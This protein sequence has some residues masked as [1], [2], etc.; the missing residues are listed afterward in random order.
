MNKIKKIRLLD[1]N[2]YIIRKPVFSFNTLFDE[3]GKTKDLKELIVFFLNNDTFKSSIYWSSPELYD[4]MIKYCCN[5][6]KDIKILKLENTLK[7][8]IIRSTTRSVPY[9]IFAGVSLSNITDF[10]LSTKTNLNNQYAYCQIDRFLYSNIITKIEEDKIIRKNIKYQI[11]STI[12][13]LYSKY[14]YIGLSEGEYHLNTVN[15]TDIIDLIYSELS[16]KSYTISEIIKLLPKEYTY[17]ERKKFTEELIDIQFLKSEISETFYQ[18]EE[19][20]IIENFLRKL[21][22]SEELKFFLNLIVSIKSLIE[23]INNSTINFIPFD[24][25]N[26]IKSQLKNIGINTETLL[27]VDLKISDLHRNEHINLRL[28]KNITKAINHLNHLNN[29]NS[30]SELFSDFKKKFSEVYEL[31][32][33]PLMEVLDMEVGI[34]FPIEGTMGNHYN[35]S[36]IDKIV[37][38]NIVKKNNLNWAPEWLITLI[39]KQPNSTNIDLSFLSIPIPIDYEIKQLPSTFYILGSV[40]GDNSFFIQ[41]IGGTSGKPLFGRFTYLDDEIQNLYNDISN[42]EKESDPDVI[43][44]DIIFIEHGK[45]GNVTRPFNTSE[46][47]INIAGESISENIK[48]SLND[49]FVSIVNDEVILRS[50]SLNKRII[51]RL[52]NAH[53]FYQSN[54]AVYKFLA[55]IENQ[56][57][58]QIDLNLNY[59]KS[60]KKYIPRIS[61][62][63]IILK[64]ATWIIY[65]SEIQIILQ[66][67]N[68]ISTCINYLKDNLVV[69]FVAITDGDNELFIDIFNKSYLQILI[70]EMKRSKTIILSEWL[71]PIPIE[72]DQ[73]LNQ[74]IIPFKNLDY[75]KTND[76]RK[77][78]DN[79]NVHKT[80]YPGSQWVYFKIYCNATYSDIILSELIHPLL[81]NWLETNI[82]NKGYFLRY[83]D[84]DYHIRF[85]VLLNDITHFSNVTRQFYEKSNQLINQLS[86]RK[87]ELSTYIREIERYGSSYIEDVESLFSYDSQFILTLLSD[88]D[89]SE[90]VELRV[91]LAV[92]NIDQLLNV[93]DYNLFQKLEFCKKMEK[94]FENE[95]NQTE[96]KIIYEKY[97]TISTFLYELMVYNEYNE[98]FDLRN[99]KLLQLKLREHSIPD[100]IHMSINR[101]FPAKQR[102]YEY[103]VYIFIG[104]YYSFQISRN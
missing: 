79:I 75:K 84:P 4:N 16:M 53:N 30:D 47:E 90:D 101:W 32:E 88:T 103:L 69:Q 62:G 44:A 18:K 89:F 87:V 11:N 78:D 59:I 58:K 83:N 22:L 74:V 43:I 23:T 34:G 91:L 42:Y 45:I 21:S 97:R 8:Y 13:L 25:I 40:L 71:F 57:S 81:L 54:I 29:K 9:G 63:G 41:N 56:K 68:S 3:D 77:I 5:D 33:M 96:K 92:K 46:F 49:L 27:H 67:T 60:Q 104:K 80:F 6:L 37:M 20:G 19:L 64:R 2:K 82:V 65:E 102:L 52:N 50:A 86:I 85:R 99:S 17:N 98:M 95:F 100:I 1:F 36:I 35:D 51:P 28:I 12:N 73:Y 39:E 48:I 24:Q 38:S 66:S 15:Q 14:R 26:N 7:K 70:G 55:S 10:N 94:S 76:H 31:N 72:K 61:Y 93:F